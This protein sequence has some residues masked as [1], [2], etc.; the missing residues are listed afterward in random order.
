MTLSE[1][2]LWLLS[3]YRSSEINGALFFGRVA[4]TLRPSPLQADVTHHF[5]DEAQHAQHW[6]ECIEDLGHHAAKLPGSY[7][8]QYLEAVGLP[9]S[10]M[11]VMAI[12][13]VFEKRVIGQYQLH[14]RAPDTHPRIRQTIETIM[15]D[16]RWH[17]KYVREALQQMAQRYGQERID[18]ALARFTA[19][20]EE[21]YAK[22]LAEYGERIGFLR[23][24][25]PR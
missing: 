6:T 3:F 24:T 23:A 17:V 21:I 18:A 2:D 12:T 13:Q 4:R 16:E 1:N 9:T 19:A 7:Q 10:L 5:A 20:D 11:E 14:L 15:E 22:T 8:D 25:D